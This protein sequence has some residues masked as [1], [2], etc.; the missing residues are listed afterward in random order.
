MIKFISYTGKYPTLCMGVLTVEINGK[1]YKFGHDF[2]HYH[3]KNNTY[4][5]EDP[6]NQNFE[7]FWTSG[8]KIC[9]NIKWD[10]WTEERKWELNNEWDNCDLKHPQWVI[11]IIPQLLEIFNE[12]VQYGCCGGCI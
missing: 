9:K 12:N 4:D 3:S 8:G 11:D 5:N 6:N 1:K 7:K 10:M 2:E